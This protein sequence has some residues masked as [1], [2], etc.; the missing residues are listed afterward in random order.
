VLIHQ[1]AYLGRKDES[2]SSRDYYLFFSRVHSGLI[3]R[4]KKIINRLIFGVPKCRITYRAEYEVSNVKNLENYFDVRLNLVKT[5]FYSEPPP[6]S[7][8]VKVLKSKVGFIAPSERICV[9]R[10][11]GDCGVDKDGLVI[12]NELRRIK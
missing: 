7:L 10:C 4:A 3:N 9:I 2:V 8:D 12:L 11:D 6:D 5:G 1:D